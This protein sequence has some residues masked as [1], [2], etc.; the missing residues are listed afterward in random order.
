M[1]AKDAREKTETKTILAQNFEIYEIISQIN[2][3]V[4]SGYYSITITTPRYW[5]VTEDKLK[6][7]G[8]TTEQ[9]GASVKISWQ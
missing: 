1:T 6:E 2:S 3:A 4:N 5:S 9:S 8:Y 7:L